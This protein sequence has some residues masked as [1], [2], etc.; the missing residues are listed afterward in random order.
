VVAGLVIDLDMGHLLLVPKAIHDRHCD[1]SSWVVIR[2]DMHMVIPWLVLS[3]GYTVCCQVCIM[4]GESSSSEHQ[5]RRDLQVGS[6][7]MVIGVCLHY[8]GTG[9]WLCS[10]LLIGSCGSRI[11]SWMLLVRAG[12]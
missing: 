5:A 3:M 8:P 11:G 9:G 4:G 6:L 12:R 10:F 1:T 7:E 2:F